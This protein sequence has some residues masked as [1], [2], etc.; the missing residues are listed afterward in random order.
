MRYH[1][2]PFEFVNGNRN[3]W[4]TKKKELQK[5]K[6]EEWNRIV[7]EKERKDNSTKV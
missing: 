4:E 7:G 6:H 1:K 3:P 5:S 2:I